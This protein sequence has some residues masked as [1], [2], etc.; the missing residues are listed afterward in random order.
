MFTPGGFSAS[1]YLMGRP[2]TK[3][4]AQGI[5]VFDDLRLDGQE[6]NPVPNGALLRY[7]ELAA[8]GLSKQFDFGIA[9]SERYRFSDHEDYSL[10]I[11]DT[12]E[13]GKVVMK[14]GKPDYDIVSADPYDGADV[15]TGCWLCLARDGKVKGT[16]I[17][18]WTFFEEGK[19]VREIETP[20]FWAKRGDIKNHERIYSDREDSILYDHVHRWKDAKLKI[21]PAKDGYTAVEN[22]Q[23][24]EMQYVIWWRLEMECE[25][26]NAQVKWQILGP[27]APAPYDGK[28]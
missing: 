15:V 20:M 2:R 23:T 7:D 25:G 10:R 4:E 16:G 18:L 11:G 17:W 14:R 19:G 6:Y 28:S 27:E 3:Y 21:D 26:A 22:P 1:E 9:R 5:Q 12:D 13:E 24:G 8:N